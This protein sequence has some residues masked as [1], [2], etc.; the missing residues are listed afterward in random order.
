MKDYLPLGSVVLLKGTDKPLMIYGRRQIHLESGQEFEY[1]G[2]LYPEGYITDDLSFFFNRDDV[3]KVIC[4]G[5]SD[6]SNKAFVEEIL[7]AEDD[8]SA[9]ESSF[10]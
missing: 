2:C 1:L 5:Y 9:L 6:A 7:N 3:A 4:E 8:G 10:Q